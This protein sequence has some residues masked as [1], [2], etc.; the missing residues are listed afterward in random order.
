MNRYLKHLVSILFTLIFINAYSQTDS[1][2]LSKISIQYHV[3]DTIETRENSISI[4]ALWLKDTIEVCIQNENLKIDTIGLRNK[5]KDSTYLK[6]QEEIDKYLE[7]EKNS[8]QNCYSYA[9]EKYF[10]KNI[11]FRQNI[12]NK[13]SRIDRESLEKI[14]NTYFK[15]ITEFE[16]KPKRNLKYPIP[17]DV[18]IAFVNNYDWVN[19]TVYYNNGVVYSKNGVF[20]PVEYQSLKELLKKCYWDTQKLIIYKADENKIKNICAN[21]LS[22][23]PADAG[24]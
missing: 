13:Y 17:N 1:S 7:F 14:L 5:L 19:H 18:I 2:G 8:A 11:S 24:L 22:V 12:F 21:I 4:N 16:A 6:K 23:L 15:V 20:K 9:L 10:A 3:L